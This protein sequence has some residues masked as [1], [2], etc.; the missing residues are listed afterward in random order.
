MRWTETERDGFLVLSLEGEIDLQHSP[1]VREVLMRK[2]KS[3][4]PVL[5]V[6]FTAVSYIDSSGL[7]TIVEYFRDSR[8]FSGKLALAGMNQRVRTIFDLVRLGEFMSI[9]PTLD[10]AASAL[11]S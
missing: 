6:D 4:C 3:R 11:K 9:F 10:E 1:E 2:I 8:E 7:A 5:V